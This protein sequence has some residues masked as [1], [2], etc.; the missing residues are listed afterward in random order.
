MKKSQTNG[1]DITYTATGTKD[2]T[3]KAKAYLRDDHSYWFTSFLEEKGFKE[4]ALHS[5]DWYF[6][7][8]KCFEWC[9]HIWDVGPA[10]EDWRVHHRSITVVLTDHG[11]ET[12]LF[13]GSVREEHLEVLFE[14][15]DIS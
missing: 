5:G 9:Y 14:M 2:R 8:P 6:T 3:E 15:L 10:E 12:V 13:N 4:K 1:K 11:E 7:S